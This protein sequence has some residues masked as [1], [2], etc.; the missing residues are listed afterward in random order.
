MTTR[1]TLDDLQRIRQWHLAHRREQPLEGH[2]WDGV[3]TLWMMG[4]LGWVPALVIQAVWALPLCLMAMTL[5]G[6]YVGWRR[7]AHLR[8]RLRCD[9]LPPAP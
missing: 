1:L 5:P 8:Q 4:W 3:L 7:R 2:L 9:W 6:V